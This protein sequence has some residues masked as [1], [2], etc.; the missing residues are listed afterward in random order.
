MEIRKV[1]PIGGGESAG[2]TL[3]KD[4]LRDDG[5]IS[6]DGGIREDRYA[7]VEKLDDG[8]YRVELVGE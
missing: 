2:V 8:T 3:P 1:R 6:P 4:G 5:L 7:K